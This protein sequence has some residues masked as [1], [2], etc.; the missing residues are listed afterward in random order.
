MDWPWCSSSSSAS[1][2]LGSDSLPWERGGA[3]RRPSK[4]VKDQ[5][6]QGPWSSALSNR[7]IPPVGPSSS[8]HL[9]HSSVQS[10]GAPAVLLLCKQPT[11]RNSKALRDC[12][13]L[14]WN[15][16]VFVCPL[17]VS[18]ASSPLARSPAV[19]THST[20]AS[21]S[22]LN[23][24]SSAHTQSLTALQSIS[25]RHYFLNITLILVLF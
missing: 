25:F 21:P 17:L 6:C 13:N 8:L 5:G 14:S 7:S 4:G 24:T 19:Q 16:L 12:R 1:A 20:R 23:S 3:G 15:L 10:L 18:A 22:S 2:A 11:R 9:I